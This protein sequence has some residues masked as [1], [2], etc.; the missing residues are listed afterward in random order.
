[1]GGFAILENVVLIYDAYEEGLLMREDYE[2]PTELSFKDFV[3]R[4][5]DILQMPTG[6]AF[7]RKNVLC[8]Y[9]RSLSAEDEPIALPRVGN[10]YE[11]RGELFHR[12]PWLNKGCV[13]LTRRV[14]HWPE[15][16]GDET[17]GCI[18]HSDKCLT[19]VTAKPID[20]VFYGCSE[21]LQ[22]R[23]PTQEM[24]RKWHRA[25]AVSFPE[26]VARFTAMI[27]DIGGEDAV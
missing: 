8:F 26:S 7:W 10:V 6:R 21:P 25:L 1:M 9:P 20:C 3:L 5:F 2:F 18:L 19:H 13:F 17:R 16:D 24:S 12:N 11:T 14:P 22:P 4:Y 27:G 23:T 15:D